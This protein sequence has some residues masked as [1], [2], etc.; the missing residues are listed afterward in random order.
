MA[1]HRELTRL[2]DRHAE[3][4]YGARIASR[5]NCASRN[6][7][8]REPAMRVACILSTMSQPARRASRKAALLPSFD[9][10]NRQPFLSLAACPN[11]APHLWMGTIA[12]IRPFR[13]LDQVPRFG[14]RSRSDLTRDRQTGSKKDRID[15]DS[16]RPGVLVCTSCTKRGQTGKF[17]PLLGRIR[18]KIRAP[19][20]SMTVLGTGDG[21][22]ERA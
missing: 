8:V 6:G 11:R 10:T 16:N 4:A 14:W 9:W 5:L 7:H 20:G 21:R 2:D 18:R 22:I 12:N 19:V 17:I 1:A 15:I 13:P 3:N